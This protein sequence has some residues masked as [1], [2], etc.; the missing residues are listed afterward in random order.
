MYHLPLPLSRTTYRHRYILHDTWNLLDISSII[1]WC[2]WLSSSVWERCLSTGGQMNPETISSLPSYSW[3]AL[4]PWF[5]LD[6]WYFHRST[7]LLAPWFRQDFRWI[8]EFVWRYFLSRG[9]L[10]VD[11]FN[12]Q[13]CSVISFRVIHVASVYPCSFGF[14]Y[15]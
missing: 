7:V 3:H 4:Y 1:L 5:S 14:H 10:T 12:Y 9:S 15:L 8:T 11:L 6:Y 13:W 2:Y